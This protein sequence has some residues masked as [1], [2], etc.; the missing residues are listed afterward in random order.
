MQ[1]SLRIS[2]KLIGKEVLSMFV[3]FINSKTGT[4][5]EINPYYK[6]YQ[7]ECLP[8][9]GSV[10]TFEINHAEVHFV[11]DRIQLS[12][13]HGSKLFSYQVFLSDQEKVEKMEEKHF[14]K[15][16]LMDKNCYNG[17]GEA[18]FFQSKE[19]AVDFIMNNNLLTEELRISFSF[20]EKPS[21][22]APNEEIKCVGY[23]SYFY[24]EH[25]LY[26]TT[27]S[28]NKKIKDFFS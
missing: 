4:P 23:E 6:E 27:G 26:N 18:H 22:E 9:I 24:D 10:F 20:Y 5:V 21:L 11:V 3:Q 28:T 25:T 14:I 12:N 2:N 17:D 7:L 16:F 15:L 8:P 1:V 19:A 13:T